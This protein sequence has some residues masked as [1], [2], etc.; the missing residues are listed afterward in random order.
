MHFIKS[1]IHKGNGSGVP[2]LYDLM[3]L[4]YKGESTHLVGVIS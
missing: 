4:D 2:S 1:K 3:A